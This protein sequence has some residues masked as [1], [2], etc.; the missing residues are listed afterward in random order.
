VRLTQ[1]GGVLQ[2]VLI[3][4]LADQCGLCGEVQVLRKRVRAYQQLPAFALKK[5]AA[6]DRHARRSGRACANLTVKK[7]PWVLAD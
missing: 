5:D 7:H 1:R 4:E 2:A 3:Q 6:D